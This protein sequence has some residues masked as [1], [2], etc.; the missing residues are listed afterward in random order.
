MKILQC[1]RIILSLKNIK[2]NVK[3]RK[4][5]KKFTRVKDQEE[6]QRLIHLEREIKERREIRKQQL[7]IQKQKNKEAIKSKI[8]DQLLTDDVTLDSPYNDAMY[9]L[10]SPITFE[11]SDGEIYGDDSDENDFVYY[12]EG[13]SRRTKKKGALLQVPK[14][15][16]KKAK[17]VHLT[18]ANREPQNEEE[19][20]KMQWELI[21]KRDLPRVYRQF[22]IS[23]INVLS[24]LKKNITSMC[25]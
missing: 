20:I 2:K 16:V 9:K 6:K 15:K 1:N 4:L 24:N 17:K 25:T 14:F 11:D 12:G 19:K 21:V 22:T 5:L 18:F 23:H 13:A 3:R 10:D 8:K 7:K